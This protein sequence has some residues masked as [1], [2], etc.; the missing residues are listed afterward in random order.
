MTLFSVMKRWPNAVSPIVINAFVRPETQSL[1]LKPSFVLRPITSDDH[2]P[3]RGS[4]WRDQKNATT[5]QLSRRTLVTGYRQPKFDSPPIFVTDLLI[6]SR[7]TSFAYDIFS[8]SSYRM[9]GHLQNL[10]ASRLRITLKKGCPTTLPPLEELKFGS[11]FS[12]HMLEA[13]WN[14]SFGWGDPH[15]R[16]FANLSLHPAISSLHYGLQVRRNRQRM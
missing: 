1:I 13:D 7:S 5:N 15:I 10:K 3:F 2:V 9:E 8:F 4:I 12:D 11:F 14:S 6:R 16:P